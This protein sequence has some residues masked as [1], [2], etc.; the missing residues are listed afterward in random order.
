MGF[1]SRI[2]VEASGC[3]FSPGAEVF[4]LNYHAPRGMVNLVARF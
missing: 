3:E 1:D 2:A 4:G